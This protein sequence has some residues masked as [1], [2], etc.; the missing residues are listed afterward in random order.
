MKRERGLFIFVTLFCRSKKLEAILITYIRTE[1]PCSTLVGW[2][3]VALIPKQRILNAKKND[4]RVIIT[5]L[6]CTTHGQYLN[7]EKGSGPG[8]K[9]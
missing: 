5:A 2:A 9:Y 6:S 8:K 3:Q 1:I 4:N 7:T